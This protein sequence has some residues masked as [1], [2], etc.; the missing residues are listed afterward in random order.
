MMRQEAVE[1]E[2]IYNDDDGGYQAGYAHGCL[3][4]NALVNGIRV[5]EGDVLQGEVLAERLDPV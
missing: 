3:H 1:Q 4:G 5:L 2:R